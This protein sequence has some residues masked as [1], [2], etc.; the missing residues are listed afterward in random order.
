MTQDIFNITEGRCAVLDGIQK[1]FIN[2]FASN[3]T[4]NV[5]LYGNT[6]SGKTLLLAQ[7]L[8]MKISHYRKEKVKINVFL[9]SYCSAMKLNQ[10]FLKTHLRHLANSDEI[11]VMNFFRL[12][13]EGN[14]L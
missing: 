4:R 11:L 7:A 10:D 12:C 6:G 2:N 9:T 8:S 14:Q 1:E 13:E 3:V 5:F